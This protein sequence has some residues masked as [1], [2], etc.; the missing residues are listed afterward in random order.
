MSHKFQCRSTCSPTVFTGALI[1]GLA[2][3]SLGH[4]LFASWARIASSCSLLSLALGLLVRGW[5]RRSTILISGAGVI[6]AADGQVLLTEVKSLRLDA[7]GRGEVEPAA[8]RFQL[9]AVD[10]AGRT[11]VLLSERDPGR[12]FTEARKLARDLALRV[13][14]ALA[15][16]GEPLPREF[17]G[18]MH[19][20]LSREGVLRAI[21]R[22]PG[23]ELWLAGAGSLFILTVMAS[24]VRAH[25]AR[26]RTL[27]APSALLLLGLCAVVIAFLH[28]GLGSFVSTEQR[29]PSSSPAAPP[30]SETA[31]FTHGVFGRRIRLTFD[32]NSS[33]CWLVRI[34]RCGPLFLLL[35]REEDI[36]ATRVQ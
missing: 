19:E 23:K 35:G 25:W 17:E 2:C 16:L 20:M 28:W 8:I 6:S 27:S 30:T 32:E 7:S 12:V 5:P 14:V 3:L 21:R 1:M 22:R 34:R 15:T 13:E 26:G 11:C 24:L 9:R 10:S 36:E 31:L 18:E 4:H 33:A 29:Q